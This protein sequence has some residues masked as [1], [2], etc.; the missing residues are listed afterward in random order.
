M[1]CICL[2]INLSYRFLTT[3]V[4]RNIGLMSPKELA[5]LQV[6]DFI[7]PLADGVQLL[8]LARPGDNFS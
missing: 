8:L 6:L 7:R 5:Y 1:L 3:R 4:K 2:R